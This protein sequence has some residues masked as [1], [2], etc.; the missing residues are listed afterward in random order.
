MTRIEVKQ[1]NEEIARMLGYR[2]ATNSYSTWWF[3]K[4]K[5]FK[6]LTFHIDWNQ[7]IKAI[8]FIEKFNTIIDSNTR[9][10]YIVI[11][12]NNMCVV[13]SK[14][15]RNTDIISNYFYHDSVLNNVKKESVFIAV[16]NFAKFYNNTLK[17]V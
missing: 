7:L 6:R 2:S 17:N 11:I 3:H 5:G 13:T 4:N 9:Q 10:Y 14:L 8:E 1:R 15:Y 12:N 16:S